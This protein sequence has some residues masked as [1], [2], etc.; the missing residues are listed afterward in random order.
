MQ[1]YKAQSEYM[2]HT[3]GSLLWFTIMFILP[4]IVGIV[5][6][7]TGAYASE[8]NI[9]SNRASDVGQTNPMLEGTM[10]AIIG[11]VFTAFSARSARTSMFWPKVMADVTIHAYSYEDIDHP[12]D[13]LILKLPRLLFAD[14]P[15]SIWKGA[16]ENAGFDRGEIFLKLPVGQKI[17]S[18]TNI[19]DLHNLEEDS[20][21]FTL[22]KPA[23]TYSDQCQYED[24]GVLEVTMDESKWDKLFKQG[25]FIIIV[26]ILAVLIMALMPEGS[27]SVPADTGNIITDIQH[28]T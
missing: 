7:V 11:F 6:Y 28:F 1:L 5:C 27:N 13:L 22:S 21:R 16:A 15:G 19:Y 14:R 23:E 4:I 3:M 26:K 2:G 9:L 12:Y 10:V 25:P 18:I 20:A 17:S 24:I 8:V